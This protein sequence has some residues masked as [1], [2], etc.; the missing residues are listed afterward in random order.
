MNIE[1]QQFQSYFERTDESVLFRQKQEA[2][3]QLAPQITL[4]GKKYSSLV[5]LKN[6]DVSP[7][8]FNP[9]TPSDA[10][11]SIVGVPDEAVSKTLTSVLSEQID[12]SN[13]YETH[14]STQDDLF[15]TAFTNE[16]RTIRIHSA[17]KNDHHIQI[18]IKPDTTPLFS[19]IYLIL[20]D[21]SEST[22]EIYLQGEQ[23][24][25]SSRI[26][27]FGHENAHTSITQIEEHDSTTT[28]LNK[29][30]AILKRN[31]SVK[32]STCTL[33]GA[34]TASEFR[35][36]LAGE[37]ASSEIR[38]MFLT[39]GNEQ[40]AIHAESQHK[41][42]HTNSTIY[43]KGAVLDRAHAICTGNINISSNAPE[44]EGYETQ[45]LLVVSK[46][47]RSDA[48]P[49]LEINNHNVSCSHGSTIGQI[50]SETLYYL[51]SR[52]IPKK[53]AE[54]LLI[55]GFFTPLLSSLSTEALRKQL[56]HTITKTI[57][58]TEKQDL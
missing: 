51:M 22:I 45:N 5:K 49:N 4:S 13:L 19:T 2:Y 25:H 29:T 39:K 46:H 27:V 14:T 38:N 7:D 55:Q 21:Q 58:Q 44:S 1:K 24:F 33:G 18:T 26:I 12:D 50:D 10:M 8:K 23:T 28:Y 53:R 17:H 43:T 41:S 34:Y 16:V 11:I 32:L 31:T 20:E 40:H 15:H 48:I 3:R 36:I 42:P 37:N 52:G 57:E 30:T 9:R 56:E 6:P 35:A 47:A 54:H